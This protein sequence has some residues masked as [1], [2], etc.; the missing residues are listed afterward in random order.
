M[1]VDFSKSEKEKIFLEQDR[2]Y[3][4]PYHHTAHFLDDGSAIRLRDLNWGFDYLACLKHACMI[5]E[6]HNPDSVLEVGCGDG[7]IIGSLNRKI[8]KLVG[9]DLS[10]KAIAF[11]KA[12]FSEI[13]FKVQSAD[14]L[15]DKF[16]AVMAVEVLEHIPDD[17]V[18]SFLKSLEQRTN[19]GG[20]IY[21]SVPS[22]NLPIYDK[23]YR[24]YD[25][26]LLRKQIHEA[27][28]RVDIVDL[29][30]FRSPVFLENFY[31]RITK[32]RFWV[33]EFHPLRRYI[34]N[35]IVDSLSAANPKTAQHVIAVLKKV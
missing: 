30:F 27:D 19:S 9:V 34:W 35:N 25:P 26:S 17:Q 5:V 4:F 28:L 18:T 21:I 3:N 14:L 12:F 23:H 32:N 33:A 13:E 8:P 11:A 2:Q 15:S 31:K 6:N 24:H 10:E 20:L 29:R 16:D 22:I 1:V 7:A